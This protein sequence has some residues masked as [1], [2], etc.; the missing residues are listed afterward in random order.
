ML[1]LILLLTL[2]ALILHWLCCSFHGVHF[3]VTI[4]SQNQTVGYTRR[5]L[6]YIGP[7]PSRP[8]QHIGPPPADWN[9]TNLPH[10]DE[11]EIT[12][13]PAYTQDP[14][15]PYGEVTPVGS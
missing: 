8:L 9:D 13:P 2:S 14:P 3:Q 15:P 11:M 12:K 10:Y 1:L 7:P 6:Q 4:N 5:P